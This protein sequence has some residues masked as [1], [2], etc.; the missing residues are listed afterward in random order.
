MIYTITPVI[1]ELF[2]A[3]LFFLFCKLNPPRPNFLYNPMN[4]SA[5]PLGTKK[6][7]HFCEGQIIRVMLGS[8]TIES[9]LPRSKQ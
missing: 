6:P 2:G 1:V 7:P 8:T 5:Y 3:R 9:E 4:C